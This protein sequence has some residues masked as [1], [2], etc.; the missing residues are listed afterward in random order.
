[1]TQ[2]ASQLR[3]IGI[4][5]AKQTFDVC[6]GQTNDKSHYQN[7][8]AGYKQLIVMDCYMRMSRPILSQPFPRRCRTN[9]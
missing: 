6:M 3:F 9:R 8:S 5:M 2:D 1:M 7:D 4:D